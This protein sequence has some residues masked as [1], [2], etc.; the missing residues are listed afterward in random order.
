MSVVWS[1]SCRAA[2]NGPISTIAL[3]HGN[4]TIRVT[5]TPIASQ[6]APF[7]KGQTVV[8]PRTQVSATEQDGHIAIVGGTSLQTLVDGLNQIGMKPTDI[9]AILQSIKT[10]G[11]LQ[12][13]LVVQ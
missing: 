11:A 10:S 6:P 12:A 4:L 13:E 9:I 3:T 8:L 7:S 5:E 1:T 2:C